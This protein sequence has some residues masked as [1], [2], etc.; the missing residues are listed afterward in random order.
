MSC[1]EEELRYRI[2]PE[3]LVFE[4]FVGVS[5]NGAKRLKSKFNHQCLDTIDVDA[6]L[7]YL[8]FN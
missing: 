4:K 6:F 5:V 1:V 7:N 2:P 3:I 8:F